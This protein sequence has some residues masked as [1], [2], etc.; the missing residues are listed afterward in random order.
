VKHY[1]THALVALALAIV[2]LSGLH[3]KMQHSLTDLRFALTARQATG[4]IVIV[5]IDS[6]SI[7]RIGTWPWSRQLHADLLRK[8][9]SAGARDI[10]FDVDF[11]APSDAESDQAFVYA[12]RAASGSVVLPSFV[13]LEGHNSNGASLHINQPIK[14]FADH[15]WSA[16]VNVSVEPDGLVRR[17]PFGEKLDGEFLPSMG[18]IL[19]G[20]QDLT[21]PPFLI[22]FGIRA[23]SVPTVSYVDVLRGDDRTLKQLK[24]K[25]VIV[26]GT[27]LELG[28]RFSIPNG[29]VVAGPLLQSLAAESIIQDRVLRPTSNLVTAFGICV[30]SLVMMFSWSR[31]RAGQRVVVLVGLAVA[32][33]A[34][35][36]A[37]QA[38]LPVVLDTSLLH[39]AI[40]AY[41][42][43][44]ALDEINI[45]GLLT[46]VAERRFQRIAM[47]LGDGLMC[48]DSDRRITFWNPAASAI[49]G[50]DTDEMV[51]RRL[52][53][54]CIVV[55]SE[56]AEWF[57]LF[58]AP[59]HI[60]SL[61]GGQVT[62]LEGRRKNGEAFP[63]EICLS[64]WQ[65]A[66]SFQYGAVLR[67]ISVR[68][69]EEERIRYLAE[70][71]TLTGLPN[72]NS[73]LGRL[74]SKMA[75][76]DSGP[77]QISLLLISLDNLHQINDVLGHASGDGVLCAVANRLTNLVGDGGHLARLDGDEFAL[78][79][80]GASVQKTAAEMADRILHAFSKP[81]LC[82]TR[83][84]RIRLSIGGAI[85]PEHGRTADELLGNSHLALY[86]AKIVRRGSHVFFERSIR[87]LLESR[88]ML[89]AEL[90]G[91]LDRNEF[92]LFY[93][94]QVRLADRR[95]IGAE[96]LIRWRH[97]TR[98]LISP[99]EFMPIVN[100]SPIS[101]KIAAWVMRTA[102]A[103]GCAW[104]QL[105]HQL[106]IGVNLA[107]SQFQSGDLATVVKGTLA[108]TGLTPSLLELEVTEDILLN[109]AEKTRDTFS[110]IQALGVRLVFDDFGTG[111]ASLSYLKNF[112]LDGLKIDKSFVLNLNAEPAEAVIVAAT[113]D[114]SKK[115]GQS[116]IAEGIED[117]AT[118]ELLANMGC[119][120]GQG[121]YFG[122]PMPAAN[123]VSEFLVDTRHV[124]AMHRSE[125]AA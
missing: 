74:G 97:P 100:S 21:G 86:R 124:A 113:I 44:L 85:Y 80:E 109:D 75:A 37:L 31:L 69:R 40:V 125:Q 22:D 26:G 25:K 111:Y 76:A 32:I 106:R 62:E 16:I 115:L 101:D 123:F 58:N 30:I 18:A 73:L 9:Q 119:E 24:D 17:Y 19:A 48:T 28:D 94:P 53:D 51:G 46:R 23:A 5:A 14:P 87:D 84:H 95:L 49:F 7:D 43:A 96:A 1:R 112:P 3:G 67:D 36:V 108:A 82:G 20:K 41:L 72:R 66:D 83:H 56:S 98:G 99:A 6:I 65:G 57:G 35:A 105:G 11:S 91:A 38:R 90:A 55:E 68:K 63:L 118:A 120:E 12:L 47:S 42:A 103:Q 89:E 54:V 52:D 114:L 64:G 61:P 121:Y 88:L 60:L 93:Q 59:R 4:D 8:L 117:L 70:H 50:Y 107:P 10:V 78:V 102:C 92:E 77:D 110:Q 104:E 27:A 2:L 29:N 39:T 34:T 116:V 81:L 13:Q 79:V 15:S 122:R 45:R 33:E 71:D